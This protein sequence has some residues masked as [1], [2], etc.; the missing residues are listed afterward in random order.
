MAGE[1]QGGATV[2][3]VRVAW[4]PGPTL[5]IQRVLQI[6]VLQISGAAVGL[7]PLAPKRCQ[8]LETPGGVE[9][10]DGG[11]P[12]TTYWVLLATMLVGIAPTTAA[13]EDPPL[14][15]PAMGNRRHRRG[16]FD[17]PLSVAV[18]DGG[19]LCVVDW[20]I[21]QS[22][23]QVFSLNGEFRRTWPLNRSIISIALDPNSNVF[24][25]P[26]IG[27]IIFRY[28]ADGVPLG[29]FADGQIENPS[30]VATD[31]FGNVYVAEGSGFVSVFKN[32]GALISRWPS[33]PHC[34]GIAVDDT[35]N[36]FVSDSNTNEIRKHSSDGSLLVSWGSPGAG[37]G[38]FDRPQGLDVDRAGSVY[39]SDMFNNRIQKFT[40]SGSFLSEWGR[41]GT[42][43][44][45][46]TQPKDVAVDAM[47]NIYVADSNNDRIQKFGPPDHVVSIISCPNDTVV[48]CGPSGVKVSFVVTADD[49]Q[50]PSPQISCT[51]ASGSLFAPGATTVNCTATDL[52][53]NTSSCSFEVSVIDAGCP[54]V[55]GVRVDEIAVAC[56][57][58]DSAAQ[59]I[60]LVATSSGQAFSGGLLL[61]VADR[62]G[63]I[64]LETANLFSPEP[65]GTEWPEGRRWLLGTPSVGTAGVEPDKSI[66]AALDLYGGRITLLSPETG[67]YRT[68][69]EVSY[70]LLG[71]RTRHWRAEAC[72]GR[73]AARW[74]RSPCP[75]LRI[76]RGRRRV[77][78]A[79]ASRTRS[80]S[81]T[82]VSRS[83]GSPAS[84]S[85]VCGASA[86][87]D[88]RMGTLNSGGWPLRTGGT[89]TSIGNDVYFVVGPR[90]GTPVTLTAN[91]HL[92]LSGVAAECSYY[93]SATAGG[94]LSCGDLARTYSDNASLGKPAFGRDT[95]L[96]ISMALV[97]HQ[98]FAL[99]MT[100][101][102][103]GFGGTGTSTG[104]LSFSGLPS[105]A[106]VVSCQGY[107]SDTSVPTLISVEDVEAQ[108]DRIRV[109]WYSPNSRSSQYTVYRA[110]H[111]GAWIARASILSSGDGH[112]VYE[113]RVVVPGERYGYRLGGPE[114][115]GQAILGE[116]WVTVP[117]QEELGLETPVPNPSPIDVTVRFSLRGG[118][119]ARIVVLDV[120]GRVLLVRD[121]R[122]VGAGGMES[123][124]SPA[125]PSHPGSIS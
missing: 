125:D 123:S 113:D 116:T 12:R 87:Y 73:R 1:R 51:P 5:G 71:R 11:V 86:D 90:A 66:L 55:S 103:S 15:H 31:R 118:L 97:S 122:G 42:G 124:S 49:N 105:A 115:S 34:W 26:N 84:R 33:P 94:S 101:T 119:P 10:D 32:D 83:P 96:S 38:Q 80:R 39:V 89:G 65:N 88:L 57:N 44:G 14:I 4:P 64:R 17:Y 77:S 48:A 58:G 40:G 24:A 45:E 63:T 110:D 47:G 99:R 6:A 3:R 37:P 68:I 81:A 19:E 56:A 79:P 30:G 25:V 67:G 111:P 21:S 13:A 22:R 18:L 107:V 23:L 93:A 78:R 62:F 92:L 41:E 85:D 109:S 72:K 114:G 8:V 121:L 2:Y 69:D 104:T 117:R 106:H 35:G 27:S 98:P 95:T 112:I 60:E 70:G 9:V 102:A 91:F 100:S 108:W 120:A 59:F 61:R 53:S 82:R 75:I 43:T 52:H 76:S 7:P 16:Q 20:H 36:V 74:S 46:F 28:G 54:E 50:D 29:G